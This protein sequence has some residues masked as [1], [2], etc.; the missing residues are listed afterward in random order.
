M[1]GQF[2]DYTAP[3]LR[4][5]PN[6]RPEE[7]PHGLLTPPA[8]VRAQ[9]EQE[10]RKHPAEAFAQGE[11]QILNDWTLAYYFDYLGHEVLYRPTPQGPE[12]LAVGDDEVLTLKKSLPLQEQ[13]QLKTFLPY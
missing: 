6:R 8:E 7:L 2:T 13:L 12:V 9:I 4:E 3:S 11:A 1:S 5:G 10:R